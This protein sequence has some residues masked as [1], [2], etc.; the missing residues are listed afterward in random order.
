M[1][2][3][4][5]TDLC[6]GAI[7]SMVTIPEEKR[8]LTG[9][10]EK[11]EFLYSLLNKECPLGDDFSNSKCPVRNV[12]KMKAEKRERYVNCLSEEQID[13]I[14]NYHENCCGF[15]S[16]YMTNRNDTMVGLTYQ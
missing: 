6:G 14:H 11:K 7:T 13:F 16:F 1:K 9:L 15:F 4:Y 8:R 5:K 3:Y 2:F 10:S 12:R